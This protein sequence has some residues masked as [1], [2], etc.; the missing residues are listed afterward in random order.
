MQNILLYMYVCKFALIHGQKRVQLHTVRAPG[1][2]GVLKSSV[3]LTSVPP[4]HGPQTCINDAKQIELPLDS[5]SAQP[6][7][8]PQPC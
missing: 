1:V 4:H 5:T 6:H 3:R 7:S 8:Q 2:G